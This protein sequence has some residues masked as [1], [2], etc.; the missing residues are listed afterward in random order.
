MQAGA[1]C[2]ARGNGGTARATGEGGAAAM[3]PAVATND[4][5]A[6]GSA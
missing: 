5:K 3:V 1:E 4:K 6:E 2:E